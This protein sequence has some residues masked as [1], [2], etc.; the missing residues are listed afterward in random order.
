MKPEHAFGVTPLQLAALKGNRV[1]A[2]Q[3]L[4]Q[5]ADILIIGITR[6]LASS[7]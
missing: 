6:F 2:Q 7:A 1:R 4:D 3:L 5:N